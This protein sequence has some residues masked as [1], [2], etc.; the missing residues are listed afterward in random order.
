MECQMG[1]NHVHRTKYAKWK[2]FGPLNRLVNGRFFDVF[3][4]ELKTQ[5]HIYN[6]LKLS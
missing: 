1:Q 5:K 4:H 2:L 3:E 6:L